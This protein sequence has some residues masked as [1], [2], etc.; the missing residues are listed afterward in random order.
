MGA[1]G[2]CGTN[3]RELAR[4]GRPGWRPA[5]IETSAPGALALARDGTV[6]RWSRAVGA[7]VTQLELGT[8]EPVTAIYGVSDDANA[9]GGCARIG[10]TG[11]RCWE[12]RN[13]GGGTGIA[14]G[15]CG[16]LGGPPSAT[17]V[18]P[19]GFE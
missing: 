12:L 13:P 16:D 10:S 14:G 1:Q 5:E 19:R 17:V 2:R 6:W 4:A 7:S 11:L 18:T 3:R 9:S 8:T 15:A